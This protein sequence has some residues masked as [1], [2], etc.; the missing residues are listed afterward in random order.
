MQE[1]TG[2]LQWLESVHRRLHRFLS[3]KLYMAHGCVKKPSTLPIHKDKGIK[4]PLIPEY[5]SYPLCPLALALETNQPFS[6]ITKASLTSKLKRFSIASENPYDSQ[7]YTEQNCLS[8][9]PTHQFTS[10]ELKYWPPRD[11]HRALERAGPE[12]ASPHPPQSPHSP[13]G[14]AAWTLRVPGS[15]CPLHYRQPTFLTVQESTHLLHSPPPPSCHPLN[16]KSP[17]TPPRL[18]PAHSTS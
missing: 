1:S 3:S 12:E 13:H 18:S 10:T 14:P 8:I 9:Q 7:M 11:L 17:Q 2:S 16:C 15:R 4:L 5:R 6:L